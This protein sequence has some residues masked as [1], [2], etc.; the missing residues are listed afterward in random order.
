MC[1]FI[2]SLILLTSPLFGHKTGVLFR[3]ETS[4]GFVWKTFGDGK[5]QPK[6]EGKIKNGKVDGVRVLTYPFDG[7][8]VVGE[9][10]NGKERNHIFEG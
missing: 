7:K 10:R 5:V 8:S 9:W 3:Y 2:L 6:Y 4:S 1:F